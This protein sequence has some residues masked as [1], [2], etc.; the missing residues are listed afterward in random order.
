MAK[1]KGLEQLEPPAKLLTPQIGQI[2]MFW[3]IL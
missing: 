1:K 3:S 2:A